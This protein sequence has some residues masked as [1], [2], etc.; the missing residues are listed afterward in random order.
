MTQLTRLSLANRLIVGM[1]T[2]A[3]VIFGVL[4]TFLF[5]R[6]CSPRPRCRPPS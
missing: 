6:S 2:L 5:A 1:A 4:A 3:I